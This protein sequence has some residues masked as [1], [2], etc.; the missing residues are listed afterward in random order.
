MFP[1]N[2]PTPLFTFFLRLSH[3]VRPTF[4]F[5]SIF[6]I[7]NFP[8]NAINVRRR[9]HT[10]FS[11]LLYQ[12]I[13]VP[14]MT[15]SAPSPRPSCNH[16]KIQWNCP[17]YFPHNRNRNRSTKAMKARMVHQRILTFPSPLL[18]TQNPSCSESMFRPPLLNPLIQTT[19]SCTIFCFSTLPCLPSCWQMTKQ[20][21]FPTELATT[22]H[23]NARPLLV[24][25]FFHHCLLLLF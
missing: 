22:T 17:Y 3:L 4:R 20:K 1:S 14:L 10:S 25:L 2:G 8:A 23:P 11:T 15:A 18:T 9:V 7:R 6:A 5:Q 19:D 21:K 16:S 12:P 24:C 13:G